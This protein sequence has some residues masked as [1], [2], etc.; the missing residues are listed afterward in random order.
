[1]MSAPLLGSVTERILTLPGWLVPTLVFLL[2][3]LEASA[4]VGFVFPGEIVVLLGGVAAWR[5]TVPLWAVIVAAVAGAIIGDTAGYFIGRRWGRGMLHGTLGRLPIVRRHLDKHLDAAQAYVRRRKGSAVF[6]GRFTTALRVLVPG[7]AGM[8]DVH[9][10]TF[11]AY[12]VAG[13]VLWGTGFALLGYLAGASYRH[14]A[15]IASRVGL[16]LLGLIVMGL[17]LGRLLRRMSRRSERIRAWIARAASSAPATWTKRRFPAQVAWAGRRLTLSD[18]RGFPL[19]F[20]L[21]VAALCAWAFAG[22]TQDVVGHDETYLSDPHVL[23]WVVA[24]RSDVLTSFFRTVTWLGSTA[25]LYPALVLIAALFWWRRRDWRSGALLAASLLGAVILYYA[26]KSIVGRPRPPEQFWIGHYS[27][28]AF[29]SGHATQTIAFYGMLAF[30][31]SPG[32]SLRARTL[33]WGGAAI[34]TL[35]V[36]GSRLYLGAHWMTDVLGGYALGATWASLV[37]AFAFWRKW[38]WRPATA[39]PSPPGPDG[40]VGLEP[41][42][43]LNGRP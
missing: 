21:A 4:F 1:M 14:V 11:L 3:A 33:L 13:G 36:G 32:R 20:A 2:P 19:T 25:V 18:P 43:A 31:L 28:W 30:L 42:G 34:V 5:G 35:V 39:G 27:G 23:S 12:N 15:G 26:V 8:S 41:V 9:Y 6:F 38:H 37:I 40:L 10:P 29:P 22:L 16:L 24:H 7:L 17:I